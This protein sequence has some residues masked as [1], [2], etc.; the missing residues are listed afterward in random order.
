MN[1][2][3][4]TR[5]AWVYRSLTGPEFSDAVSGIYRGPGD[6]VPP[7]LLSPRLKY[8]LPRSCLVRG[9]DRRQLL[10]CLRADPEGSACL[11]AIGILELEVSPYQD[12]VVW[13]KYI[14]VDPAFQRQG[15]ARELLAM[16]VEHLKAHPRKLERS[17][18][19]E[20]G[21]VRIKGYIDTLLNS[22]ELPWT[23]GG[24]Y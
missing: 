1:A 6:I 3:C 15:I 14:T 2:T 10:M 21:A 13:L 7:W 19:S 12:D 9:P 16:M 8:Y 5:S 23:Q 4:A 11:Q 18:P 22:H 17:R 24:S 20:E